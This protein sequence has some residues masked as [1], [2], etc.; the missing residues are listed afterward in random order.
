M[1]T[2]APVPIA[3]LFPQR[4]WLIGFAAILIV[5]IVLLSF[6]RPIA[7][8]KPAIPKITRIPV[9]A[10]TLAQ[11]KSVRQT[12][13]FPALVV[14]QQESKV[15]AKSSGSVQ[16]AKVAL[17]DS[18]LEGELL[19]VIDDSSGN[20]SK[21]G[22][23][24]QARLA[25]EQAA[26]AY[27][28]AQTNYENLLE[29]S[30]KDLRQAEISRDQ[31]QT[32]KLNTQS[33]TDQAFKTAQL[34]VEQARLAL[35]N[36]KQTATQAENDARTNGSVV[37]ENAF[38]ASQSVL[39]G[40]NNITGFDENNSTVIPY[41]YYLGYYSQ[42]RTDAKV[43]YKEA[44]AVLGEF[45]LTRF[46]SVS[47][48]IQKTIF[49]AEQVRDL[50]DKVKELLDRHT[51]TGSLL[52]LNSPT[53][54]SL[55]AFQS[56]VAGYQIQ[57][58]G[59]IAQL[60]G[61]RQALDN[62]ALGNQT[63]LDA[64]EKAYDLARQN[65][66]SLK[67]TSGNQIDQAGF[68]Q[69]QAENQ[70]ENLTIKLETQ[71]AAAKAQMD[72]A[73]LQ[74]E[75]SMVGLSTLSGNYQIVAP[76][77]GV[78]TRKLFSIGDTVA[79]GQLLMTVSRPDLAKAQFFV[80]SE[81]LPYIGVGKP[82]LLKVSNGDSI[83]A[84]IV[85]VSTRA[86]EQTKRFMVEAEPLGNAKLALGTV[87]DVALELI[88]QSQEPSHFMLPLSAIDVGQ[89]GNQ[90]TVAQDG[91]ALKAEVKIVR[92]VGEAA[93]IAADLPADAKIIVEGNR[94]AQEGDYLTITNV[95]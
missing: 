74:Y 59:A 63:S 7:S 22:P 67:A 38:N 73:R 82:V 77:G 91:R 35:E 8:G 78:V 94:L 20:V 24:N 41:D 90:I 31:A 12:L 46:A 1:N 43:Q 33:I 93:E 3:N 61:A 54:A 89:N 23:V 62:V 10:Q 9:T 42:V 68:G 25:S 28:M 72:S 71:V 13:S 6:P 60:N 14:S 83:E 81:T 51:V 15:V 16:E 56:A 79:P 58:N 95:E 86:D 18:V 85:S 65:L 36:R 32:G 29:S 4:K 55:T 49:L 53:G 44:R 57:I 88:Y 30:Q 52:P 45:G 39:V 84:K 27:R 70:V 66:E 19:L 76:I 2:P 80:D 50:A 64:L 75:N 92:I 21:A 17:G 87:A 11:S 48:R 69:D 26:V 47:D 5:V 40:I 37:A 34:A